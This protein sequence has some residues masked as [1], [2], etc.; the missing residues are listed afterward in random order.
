LK[1]VFWMTLTALT[2]SLII[3]NKKQM[4]NRSH[5]ESRKV[6]FNRDVLLHSVMHIHDFQEEEINGTWFNAYEMDEIR[7]NCKETISQ[8]RQGRMDFGDVSFCTRGLER[9]AK[10]SSERAMSIQAVMEE[11]YR[12]EIMGCCDSELLAEAY[13]IYPSQSQIEAYTRGFQDQLAVCP[14]SSCRQNAIRSRRKVRKS[15]LF[16]IIAA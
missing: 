8:M 7:R 6:T 15:A 12:Q 5:Q 10:R 16:A 13:Q 9:H 1:K 11:Q 3:L 4:T 2:N 14:T